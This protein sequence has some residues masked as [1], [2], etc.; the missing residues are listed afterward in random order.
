[1]LLYVLMPPDPLEANKYKQYARY[2]TILHAS[3]PPGRL[4]SPA[5]L[6]SLPQRQTPL[7][8][9]RA[10]SR[11]CSVCVSYLS[12]RCPGPLPPP[13]GAARSRSWRPY[14][15]LGAAP[16]LSKELRPPR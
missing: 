15:A 3:K 16:M 1:M 2:T 6:T 13:T 4:P 10:G 5:P 9:D 12:R 8:F 14:T 7:R 11:V